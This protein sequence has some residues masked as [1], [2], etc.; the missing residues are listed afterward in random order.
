MFRALTVN[1]WH[2]FEKTDWWTCKTTI[3]W[4][5]HRRCAHTAATTY[6]FWR[7]LIATQH[8]KNILSWIVNQPF[9]V[10]N[11]LSLSPS[12][13]ITLHRLIL[14]SYFTIICEPLFPLL[15]SERK[16]PNTR[17]KAH[18]TLCD[19]L[20]RTS[21]RWISFRLYVVVAR[22]VCCTYSRKTYVEWMF[23]DFFIDWHSH[24]F[25]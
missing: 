16:K 19:K 4:N 21:T 7:P 11:V 9:R 20:I 6:A 15:F 14:F 3:S 18:R 2:Q 23:Y 17:P 12:F 5:D 8:Q 1:D 10:V 13:D 22:I 24:S 25:W